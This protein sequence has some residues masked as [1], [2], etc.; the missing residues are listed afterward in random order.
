M[1]RAPKFGIHLSKT[2]CIGYG[3][4]VLEEKCWG[5]IFIN[6]YTMAVWVLYTFAYCSPY[7]PCVKWQPQR[8]AIYRLLFCAIVLRT[9][10]L[11]ILANP[12]FD[13]ASTILW[14]IWFQL[15]L[16]YCFRADT[17]Y[18]RKPIYIQRLLSEGS[19]SPNQN[20]WKWKLE[21]DGKPSE[22][23]RSQSLEDLTVSSSD[24]S[25][26]LLEQHR[27]PSVPL[28]NHGHRR[29]E[30]YGSVNTSSSTSV[31]NLVSKEVNYT[32]R[33]KGRMKMA[34][35]DDILV[36]FT[37]LKLRRL[38]ARGAT[39]SV[40]FGSFKNQSVAIKVCSCASLTRK[41]ISDYVREAR[42]LASFDHPNVMQLVG[43]CIV[44]PN[45]W[46]VT[47]QCDRGNLVEVLRGT[48]TAPAGLTWARR[49]YL[50]LGAAKGLEYIH[51]CRFIH[52]DIKPDNFI[53]TA[54]WV[55]KLAD[56]GEA[57]EKAQGGI[58]PTKARQGGA[59][60]S[61]MERHRRP[62]SG[63][64]TLT[65][66]SPERLVPLY[67]LFLDVNCLRLPV[68]QDSDISQKADIYSF[69]LTMWEIGSS[70][71]PFKTMDS[72]T[73][74]QRVLE[75]DIRPDVSAFPKR[76]VSLL[77][78]CWARDPMV[79]MT[80]KRLLRCWRHFKLT[81]RKFNLVVHIGDIL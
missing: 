75:H 62:S 74:G 78:S 80:A 63:A 30:T 7:I 5:N 11:L 43:C 57:K 27:T 68:G 64:G 20:R 46:I 26:P 44:P 6:I 17:D 40:H 67:S 48:A 21:D 35:L 81:L 61:T 33:R 32:D 77:N 22:R 49:L 53:V 3:K 50:M 19:L 45:V 9:V 65:W 39:S 38:V 18:F 47:E 51:S 41:T 31:H 13:V 76:F 28:P 15:E 70:E 79:R 42:V 37:S 72:F 73:A 12:C 29:S 66:L 1:T 8:P 60:R 59:S 23:N 36:D 14:S 69:G 24:P 55:V 34:A 58:E 4:Q 25:L 71:I 2:G 54:D 56:F 16:Y 10:D 52:G